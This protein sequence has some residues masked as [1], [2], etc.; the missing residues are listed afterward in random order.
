MSDAVEQQL[1]HW[2]S[3]VD[4]RLDGMAHASWAL[5]AGLREPA[6]YSLVGGG[7]RLR[8]LLLLAAYDAVG[9]TGD[10]TGLAAAIEVVHA[11]SLVHDDLPCM[12]DDH[13]RRGR[14]TTHRA[15]DVA[16]ATVVGIAMVPLA[17]EYA[18][19]AG[20]ELRL[21]DAVVRQ[22]VALLMRASGGGGM[23]G[24][25]LLDLEGERRALSVGEL[26]GVHGAKTGALIAASL[27]LGALAANA[28]ERA[29]A[30]LESAGRALG[31]AFQIADDV[32]DATASS[33]A[34]GKSA[35]KDQ[36]QSKS[37][38]ASALGVA[39]AR[40]RRDAL[41]DRAMA[42]LEGAGLR[43]P[44]LERLARFIAARQS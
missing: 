20:E 18:I 36:A 16:T 33:E 29:L 12:D 13:L 41:V 34:L 6:H 37:T 15:F 19:R 40:E 26:E 22:I 25:Q 44:P 3:H 31:L 38:Y 9:G 7:K 32:L 5:P 4:T 10:A 23:V 24:G 35:G 43:T 8:G 17:V 42:E 30:A 27:A 39:A 1:A 2:R 28:P 21:P 14:P 11:Y